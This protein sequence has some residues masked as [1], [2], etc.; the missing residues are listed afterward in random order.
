M[1]QKI[2]SQMCA[3][4]LEPNKEQIDAA[5]TVFIAKAHLETIKPIVEGYQKEVLARHNFKDDEGNIVL[6]TKRTYLMNDADFRVYLDEVAIEH[7][8]HG[9]DVKPDYCPLLIAESNL[10][11]AEGALIDVYYKVT[12]IERTDIGRLDHRR[13][14]LDLILSMMAQ[15]LDSRKI[16]RELFENTVKSLEA[17]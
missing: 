1:N 14:Y 10:I 5:K 7:K 17:Q 9:F 13:R 8:K 6:D 2:Q 3:K 11:D 4:S 16:M 12:G 15:H